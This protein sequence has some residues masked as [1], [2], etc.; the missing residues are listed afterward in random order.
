MLGLMKYPLCD[1]DDT[2]IPMK[3]AFRKQIEHVS[4]GM[5]VIQQVIQYK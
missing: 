4:T 3:T 2:D 1:K 5:R